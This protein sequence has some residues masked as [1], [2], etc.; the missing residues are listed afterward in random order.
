[1]PTPTG[2]G[3][4]NLPKDWKKSQP[5]ILVPGQMPMEEHTCPTCRAK[6]G[7]QSSLIVPGK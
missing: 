5:A 7:E 2:E 6:A 1:M 4:V 3:E